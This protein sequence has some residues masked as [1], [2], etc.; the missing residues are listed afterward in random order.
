MEW[1]TWTEFYWRD[2]DYKRFFSVKKKREREMNK[3][4]IILFLSQDIAMSAC[5]DDKCDFNLATRRAFN[6]R[7]NCRVED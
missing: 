7:E 6:L 3:E 1:T 4:L 2:S 5:V